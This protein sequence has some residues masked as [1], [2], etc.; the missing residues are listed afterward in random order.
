MLLH[1]LGERSVGL[2]VVESCAVVARGFVDGVR[3]EV[4]GR[5]GL[6][7]GEEVL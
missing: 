1:P 6:R 5:G 2:A 4:R 3:S 7:L